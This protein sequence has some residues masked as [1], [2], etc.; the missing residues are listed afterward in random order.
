[1]SESNSRES[2]MCNA[3]PYAAEMR[4]WFIDALESR[5]GCRKRTVGEIA[6]EVGI[7]ARRVAAHVYGEIRHP[8]AAEYMQAARWRDQ[9]RKREMDRL[10]N[11]L[12]ELS[13]DDR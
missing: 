13:R 9:E 1:M 4:E 3:D 12:A 2:R 7:K 10:R 5:G 11:R 6:R 8:T